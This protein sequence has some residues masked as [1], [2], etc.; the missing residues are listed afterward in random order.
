ML[1]IDI[2]D[3]A[4][5]FFFENFAVLG[6]PEGLRNYFPKLYNGGGGATAFKAA[7]TSVGTRSYFFLASHG[8][9]DKVR[10]TWTISTHQ[11]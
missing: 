4:A 10:N 5:N 2:E 1:P 7:V 9:Y 11:S 6:R 8:F 3:V